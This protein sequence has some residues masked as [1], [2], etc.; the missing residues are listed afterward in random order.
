MEA[1]HHHETL[2]TR[3]ARWFYRWR[4]RAALNRLRE[5][6]SFP[7]LSFV[8]S[9]Q[10]PAEPA[11]RAVPPPVAALSHLLNRD[12]NARQTLHHLHIVEQTLKTAPHSAFS[13]IPGSVLKHA[14]RQL[15]SLADFH[16]QA[17]LKL[18]HLQMRRRL[19]EEEAH[20]QAMESG[21]TNNWHPDLQRPALPIIE[22]FFFNSTAVMDFPDT[23]PFPPSESS[24]A[25]R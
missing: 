3:L 20:A 24:V 21:R 7:S 2:L 5:S 16:T 1:N 13:F 10:L 22:G 17:G 8:D 12:K 11:T 23:Q 19:L 6:G 15:E 18:L 4:N 14:I 9:T 25:R